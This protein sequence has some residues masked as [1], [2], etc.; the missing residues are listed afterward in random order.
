M[1]PT[2]THELRVT[3]LTWEAD[4]VLSVRLGD[5]AGSALPPWKPGAHLTLHLPNGVAREFSLCSDPDDRTSWTVAVLD[6]PASR[7]G[8]RYVH[9]ELRP[10]DLLEVSGPRNKFDLEPADHYLLIAGGIGITPVLAMARELE[11]RGADWM[12]LYAGR[13]AASMAFTEELVTIAPD[14]VRIHADDRAGG[15]PELSS[16][17][18]TTA[19]GT[20]TYVCGPEPLIEAVSLAIPDPASLRMERF[21]APQAPPRAGT[22]GSFD[23]ICHASGGVVHVPAGT[24][25]LAALESAGKNVPSSCTEGICGTCE[26]KVIAGRVD[27]RD[28]V[29]TEAEKSVGD[30]MFICVSRALDAEITLD[31]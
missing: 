11:R 15:P 6:E 22:D 29:L 20:L 2:T 25:A 27:H 28:Y 17:L 3:Q 12:L 1:E 4:G 7:G 8:S 13:S 24:T 31:L 10:G 9:R 5:P 26:T 14:R 21:R 23:I 18:G 19:P 30:V 16:L